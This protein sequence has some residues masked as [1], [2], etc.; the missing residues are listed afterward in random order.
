[1]REFVVI[2]RSGVRYTVKAQ[3]IVSAHPYIALV[4]STA[5]YVGEPSADDAV[6]LFDRD[7][8]LAVLSREHLVSEEKGESVAAPHVVGVGDA[9]PF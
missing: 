3:R 5:P 9:I 8:V 4:L 6:A 1:M 2:L 7:Q